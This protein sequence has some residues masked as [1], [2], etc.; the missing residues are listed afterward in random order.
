MLRHLFVWSTVWQHYNTTTQRIKRFVYL[1]TFSTWCEETSTAWTFTLNHH[2]RLICHFRID[3]A[4]NLTNRY[5]RWPHN[6]QFNWTV[7]PEGWEWQQKADDTQKKHQ[8]DWV[9]TFNCKRRTNRCVSTSTQMMCCV[10]AKPVLCL[11]DALSRSVDRSA[12][13]SKWMRFITW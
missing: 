1:G 5:Y 10:D 3:F 11:V 8:M 6:L 13:S 4:Q 2:C 7:T 12:L 9:L